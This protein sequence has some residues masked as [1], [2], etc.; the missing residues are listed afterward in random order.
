M[1]V[2]NTVKIDRDVPA[3]MRDGTVLRADIYRPDHS[4]QCPVLV[5]RTPYNKSHPLIKMLSL[6][7]VD[8]ASHGYVV[9]LQDTRGRYASEG[10]FYPFRHEAADGYDTIEWAASQAWSNGRVGMYGMSYM[11]VTQW[12]AAAA[13]PPHLVTIFPQ[14]TA[15]DYHDGW[16]YQS[17]AF[18]LGFS[19]YWVLMDLAGDELARLQ[20]DGAGHPQQMAELLDA[21]DHI[22]DRYY[23]L[24]LKDCVAF[25]PGLAD[26]FRDW[27]RHP[28][29]DAYWQ[30]WNI[31]LQ[32]HLIDVPTYHVGGW[33]DLFLGGTL[34]NYIG[35]FRN[36]RTPGTR[37]AQR[38]LVGPWAHGALL[39]NLTGDMDYGVRA[40]PDLLGLADIQLRWFDY[41]L[42]GEDNGI[43]GEPPVTIFVMGDNVWR[44]ESEWP[45]ART[46]YTRY[47]F[48]SRG[49]ANRPNGDGSLNT[50]A[51]SSEP[52]DIYLYDPHHP[53]PT[54]GG[55]NLLPGAAL[56]HLHGPKDQRDIEARS[57]VLTYTT[58]PLEQDIEVTGPITVTLF[59]ASSAIDTDFTAKLVDLHPDGYAQSLT[60]GIIR[61]RYRESLAQ[62][63]PVEPG[64][65]YEYTI[66]LWATSNVFRAGHCI[67]VEISSS[68]FP[69]FDRNP[70]TGHTF[71]QSTELIPAIQS[72]FH[73][74]PHPSH[75]VLPIIPW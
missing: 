10:D 46:R 32:H 43:L 68:N 61:A 40:A 31:E 63:E 58:A 47:Y 39:S 17:G 48:H 41:W 44:S 66:D 1:G 13:Q 29:E 27:V 53:V 26:Y 5:K 55:A 35:M 21:L 30:Q 72:V 15:S 70:N 59:A 34:R 51:P 2:P 57:D 36:G 38:L 75:I 16:I 11:G 9:V 37:Q 73:D 67:R 54:R 8:A 69:R 65:I 20:A 45:L 23:D 7:P 60:D 62:P 6:D 14:L 52:A 42:K 49:N 33:F 64:R 74:T 4:D 18:L 12:L 25:E 22:R 71:G 19:L 3:T 28:H 50:T 56:H 24:P